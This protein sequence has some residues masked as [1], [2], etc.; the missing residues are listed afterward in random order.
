[1]KMLNFRSSLATKW[2]AFQAVAL[3][4]ILILVGVFQYRSIR[5]TTYR[6]VENSGQAVSHAFKEMLVERPELFNR[7]TLEPVV[8]RFSSKIPNLRRISVLDQTQHVIADSDLQSV[9]KVT[10]ESKLIPML[11]KASD[12][13]AYFERGGRK[14][15]RLSSSIEGKYDPV[16]KSNIVGAMSMDLDLSNAEQRISA[17]F[18]QTM[19]VVAGFLFLFWAVQYAFMRRGFL[20]SLRLLTAA[21]LRFGKGDFSVRAR[22]RSADE[23]GQ[24]AGAFNQM[25]AEVERTDRALKTESAQRESVS[26]ALS[27]GEEKLNSILGS[28]TTVVLSASPDNFEMLYLNPAVE[29]VYGRSASAFYE[30]PNLWMKAVHF[31]DRTAVKDFLDT[32][33]TSGLAQSQH[34]ILRPDGEVRWVI[35]QGQ[36]IYGSDGA[37]LR[38]DG[39]VTDITERVVMEAT[40]QREQEFL[41]ALLENMSDG[42]VACDAEGKLT[43]FNR[44]SREFHNLPLDAIHAGRWAD[45]YSLYQADGVTP[46]TQE[47]IPLF[48]ALGGE[49]VR[50]CEM[51][52]A[53]SNGPPR[54]LLT[55]G[56]AIIDKQGN[57]LGAVVAMHDITERK[58]M[59]AELIA[60]RDA[61]LESTRLK[62]EFLANMSHEIR[63]PMNGVIGMTGL[64]LDTELTAEQKD[65]TETISSSADS[66]MTVIN[67]I[68][69]FSKIEA[70]KLRFEKLDF[71][72]LPA[73]EGPVELLAG[74]TQD[75]G[76][77]IAS[78]IESDVP[79]KLR[80]DAGRLRQVLTNL[81]G[82]AVK[83]TEAGEVVVRVTKESDT[84]THAMLRFAITDTGIGISEEARRKLFQPFVQADGS[85]TR[86]Y[87]GTG[88]GLAIS[89]QLV[90]LMGGEIGVESESGNGS[91]FWF[92]APFEKQAA[93]K[94]N[95]QRVQASL[96]N[97]RVLVVDDNETN[98]RIVERQLA[99]WGMQSTCVGSGAE[100]LTTLRREANIGAPYALAIIDMQ[101]PEMDGMMLARRIMI[102]PTITDTRLLMLT[103]LG[104][105]DDCETLRR[106]G[107]ARC[108]TKPVKQSQLFDSLA[109]IMADEVYDSLAN[110]QEAS[111]DLT[112]E[113]AVQPSQPFPE[114]GKKQ[115]RILVA[116]DNAVNQKVALSQLD[117]LGYTADAVVNGLEALH[118]LAQTPYSIV[119]MDCQMPEMDGY[120]AT[121]EIRRREQGSTQHTVV[122]AMTAH[123]L[124]GEREKCLAAGMDDYLSKPVSARELAELLNRWSAPVHRATPTERRGRSQLS[125]VTESI[126]L[127]VLEGF[128]DLQQQGAPDLIEELIVLYLSDTRLRLVELSAAMDRQDT[129]ALQ[130]ATH[131]IKGSSS[132]VGVMRMAA[133]CVELE[134]KLEARSIGE[135]DA[136][137][138]QLEEEF[139]RVV[140]TFASHRELVNQ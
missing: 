26:I 79:V 70:G 31:E 68:L 38:V 44:A 50:E 69:D 46:M 87:G 86:K 39:S 60:A 43:L 85:T 88:L 136:S 133:L 83:F 58:R 9:G 11:Q 99:S 51:V 110:P 37:P 3:G 91:T 67:D 57:R 97:M 84:E 61:A 140:A 134:E 122:I 6:D 14:Y 40:I 54:T 21:A 65:F 104:Q 93:G 7:A 13:R 108:L 100:A 24:L 35:A 123:A 49:I 90:E 117:K 71:D 42:I 1:M 47:A 75:K 45:H 66:L 131:S 28:L 106:A 89:K 74:R 112:P 29:T 52:I 36:M 127:T 59:D 27:E 96:E 80:G 94:A 92:T 82:N 30:N 77:E 2:L 116:E 64:L 33:M 114:N 129:H 16:R 22:V 25:A 115:L 111:A 15:L 72:L 62:S 120:E 5:E 125:E 63:T 135:L 10:D 81:I 126:D 113:Q 124:Q 137:Q 12:S 32:L 19:W 78:L 109:I 139:E 102:E 8:L 76:L 48:R 18:Q 34:R 118:A 101:M 95:V 4:L 121:A 105:R 55:N 98:R 119:L 20:R 23:L 128:R 138:D 53:P 107:I 130:R 73:V 103:S 17:A 132:N 41:A 56:Q